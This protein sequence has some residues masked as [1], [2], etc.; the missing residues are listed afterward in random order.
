MIQQF[1]L[2]LTHSMAAHLP[3][4]FLKLLPHEKAPHT[5]QTTQS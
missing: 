2:P 1:M 3:I 4:L 5:V